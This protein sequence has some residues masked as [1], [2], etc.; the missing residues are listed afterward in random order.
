MKNNEFPLVDVSQLG[1]ED[2]DQWIMRGVDLFR[3]NGVL[4]IKNYYAVE[5]IQNLKK[6][7]VDKYAYYLED[8]VFDN[9][10]RVGHRRTM[11]TM[12]F[13]GLFKER[14]YYLGNSLRQLMRVLLGDSFIINSLGAV[15]S[16]PG[17]KEQSVH[18]DHPNL[19]SDGGVEMMKVGPP[20][21]ITVGIPLV[22]TD[23]ICGGTKF[24]LGSHLR[25]LNSLQVEEVDGVDAS[26][27]LGDIILFDYR[28]L[29]KGMANKAD[30][31]R[32]M[33]YNVYSSPWFRDEMNYTKQDFMTLS[34][35]NYEEIL[36]EDK[37]LFS[38][39]FGEV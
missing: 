36:E 37:K 4:L 21:A 18:R 5:Y 17:A 35:A 14:K 8:K 1:F 26:C 2:S 13:E 24:W 16:L 15:V 11:L 3:K 34:R 29:H 28:I 23:E 22:K 7:F 32:P 6:E 9:A 39:F 38:W 20:Y 27:D 30:K 10:L 19:Y 33:L 25:D 31:I 12:R